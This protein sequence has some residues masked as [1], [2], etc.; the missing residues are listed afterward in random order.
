MYI[1][2]DDVEARHGSVIGTFSEDTIFYLMSRGVPREK[3]LELL[4]KGHI[5]SPLDFAFDFKQKIIET[6]NNQRR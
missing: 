1:D 3:A 2:E 6:L 5:L 4:I